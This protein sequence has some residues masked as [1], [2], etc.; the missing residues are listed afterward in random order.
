MK[1]QKEWHTCDR[2]GVE[3]K[4]PKIWYDRMFPYLRTVNLKRPWK[5]ETSKRMA[6][7]RQVWKRDSRAVVYEHNHK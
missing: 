1:H 5:N 6:H 3:I 2:C 4:K 7:L